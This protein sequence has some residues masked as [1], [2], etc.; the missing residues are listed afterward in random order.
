MHARATSNLGPSL[1]VTCHPKS[2]SLC[3]HIAKRAQAALAENGASVL[4]HDLHASNFNPVPTTS[5][6]D[7]YFAAGIPDDIRDLVT[8]L[9]TAQEL[10]IIFPV[11]MFT[12]PALLKGYF[13]RVWRPGVAFAFDGKDLHPLLTN[14]QRLTV[15]ATHGRSKSETDVTGDGSRIFFES[16]LP[17]LLPGLKSS[18]RFDL[19]ALDAHDA[20]A[21]ERDIEHICAHLRQSSETQ[22]R[23]RSSHT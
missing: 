16:S 6:L 12:M 1:I 9:Q 18:A 13:D 23:Q 3:G 4:L 22:A 2:E 21:V 8:G 14:I 20:Q 5:E 7:V 15:I 17:T 19:Y 10:V 11:W